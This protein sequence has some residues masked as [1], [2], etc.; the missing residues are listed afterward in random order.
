MED[1]ATAPDAALPSAYLA[2]VNPATLSGTAVAA[3]HIRSVPV[4]PSPR[5]AE[6]EGF[7]GGNAVDAFKASF[8]TDSW[9]AQ[10]VQLGQMDNPGEATDPNFNPYRWLRENTDADTM[11]RLTPHIQNG[12]FEDAVTPRA[13]EQMR[14]KLLGEMESREQ[15]EKSGVGAVLGAVG[16]LALDP[17]TYVGAG[18]ALRGATASA[19][20]GRLALQGG[21]SSGAQEALLQSM[22]ELRTLHESVANVGLSTLGA[23]GIGGLIEGF[24]KS[25]PHIAAGLMSAA[26]R[27]DQLAARGANPSP[28]DALMRDAG[29]AVTEHG[30][31]NLSTAA[32]VIARG[33]GV[34]GAVHTGFDKVLGRFSPIYQMLGATADSARNI[35]LRL[36]EIGPTMLTD[37]AGNLV[38]APTSANA[39][40]DLH[41][42]RWLE[43]PMAA[44]KDDLRVLNQAMGEAGGKRVKAPDYYDA[45]ARALDGR[46]DHEVG[47]PFIARLMTDYG[48]DGAQRIIEGARR[49]AQRI[50]EVNTKHIEPALVASGFLRN[51]Q[52]LEQAETKLAQLR[53]R[54]DDEIAKLREQIA[55]AKAA[56]ERGTEAAPEAAAAYRTATEQL[57]ERQ[58]YWRREIEPWAGVRDTEIARPEPLGEG[59][60]YAQLYN[61]SALARH[62]DAFREMLLLKFSGEPYEGWLR[63]VHGINGEQ[64]RALADADPARHREI[65][66]A[67]S[68]DEHY[69]AIA[70]AETR[71]SAA[72][73]RLEAAKADVYRVS[74]YAGRAEKNL[75]SDASAV[76]AAERARRV[77]A[78]DLARAEKAAAETQVRALK[79]AAEAARQNTLSRELAGALDKPDVGAEELIAAMVAGKR[80]AAASRKAPA[81]P[82]TAALQARADA[83]AQ[84]AVV[85]PLTAPP[86][87]KGVQT[88]RMA[89]LQGRIDELEARLRKLDGDIEAHSAKV[90][91]IDEALDAFRKSVEA[92]KAAKQTIAESLAQANKARN[93]SAKNVAQLKRQLVAEKGRGAIHDVVNDII[94]GI[95][96]SG[97]VP[98]GS[99]EIDAG[100]LGQTGRLKE[101]HIHYT[102]EERDALAEL[103]V[104]RQDLPGIL[105]SS[106]KSLAGH[107]SIHEALGIGTAGGYRSFSEA[108]DAVRAEYRQ[109]ISAAPTQKAKT[110]LIAERDMAERNIALFRDR[111]TGADLSGVANKDT[112]WYWGTQKSKQLALLNYLPGFGI[113]SLTDFAALLLHHRI[114]DVIKT[115]VGMMKGSFDGLEKRQIAALAHAAELTSHAAQDLSAM[116]AE[117]LAY[118]MGVGVQGSARHTITSRIDMVGARLQNAASWVSFLPQMSNYIRTVAA[119]DTMNNIA[120][121]V[122]KFGT[123]HIRDQGHL[124]TLG[125]G[126]EQAERLHRFLAEHGTRGEGGMFQPNV[127]LWGTS[128]EAKAAARDLDV[129]ITRETMFATPSHGVGDVPRFLSTHL[130]SILMQF[131]SFLFTSYTRLIAPMIQKAT[132]TQDLRMLGVLAANVGLATMVIASKDVLSAKNPLDRWSAEKA[133]ETMYDVLDRSGALGWMTPYIGATMRAA[134]MQGPTVAYRN[135]EWWQTLM[136]AQVAQAT[137]VG[138]LVNT[139]RGY[140][141]DEA[142]GEQLAKAAARISPF[143]MYAR[144]TTRL[145]AD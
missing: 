108:V 136:G 101:R 111:L 87:P 105:E 40:R 77:A 115:S 67:W 116:K 38:P 141:N 91:D 113:S 85:D 55:I 57:A 139:A 29:A 109:L 1:V 83:T 81:D 31:V 143:G 118:N 60:G 138:R 59:Y 145:L 47:Q 126:K 144:L 73:Q 130:G 43:E 30:P 90:T 69:A 14:D 28:V 48:D 62:E 125:I 39:L 97:H 52:R 10:V 3:S 26:D 74:Y 56:S 82:V 75:S 7:S 61:R 78:R 96:S 46:L 103:G 41:I 33:D 133:P 129:A 25:S 65:A 140:A 53:A 4:P 135:N 104:L 2:P 102:P 86:A 76:A 44:V 142:T 68:G 17:L 50:T 119:L 122:A 21:L 127:D 58:E 94:D 110:A 120:D 35:A 36:A 128:A 84:K 124:A 106:V 51:V 134:G 72:E 89:R 123:L 5:R 19:R 95:S 117:S 18:W 99:V 114:G 15:I 107:L 64:F 12:H 92:R 49:S 45:M 16:A 66:L 22:Q 24:R 80:A 63:Q 11:K 132:Y 42:A 9:I 98:R 79:E 131:Q 8:A 88:Q 34:G 100:A 13:A 6:T 112:L 93:L 23:G 71:L 70:R 27:M 32:P 54:R 137:N 20:I 121:R 37:K